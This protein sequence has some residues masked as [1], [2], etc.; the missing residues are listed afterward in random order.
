MVITIKKPYTKDEML[1]RKKILFSSC[2]SHLFHTSAIWKITVYNTATNRPTDIK[3][4]TR[5][6]S[7]GS[8]K[9]QGA[10]NRIHEII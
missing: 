1:V 10:I 5:C 7:K 4:F 8:N 6:E 9:N 3:R 2:T